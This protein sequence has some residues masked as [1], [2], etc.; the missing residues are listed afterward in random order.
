MSVFIRRVTPIFALALLLNAPLLF[1]AGLAQDAIAQA[2]DEEASES[3]SLEVE[4]SSELLR[5]R[6]RFR[7]NFDSESGGLDPS[8]SADA[9]FPVW[10]RPG[11]STFYF[12][13]KL[14][15]DFDDDS[16]IG[17]NLIFGYRSYNADRDRILGGYLSY[18]V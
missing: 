11:E 1:N 6:P 9:F 16:T 3:E 12:N 7:G 4:A 18:D 14:R 8:L 5:L 17:G 10:Q 13:P 2:I 15:F